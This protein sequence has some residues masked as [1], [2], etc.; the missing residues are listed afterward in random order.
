MDAQ[1]F[2]PF[3]ITII[4]QKTKNKKQNLSLALHADEIGIKVDDTVERGKE[5]GEVDAGIVDGLIEGVAN[6][7]LVVDHGGVEVLNGEGKEMQR[8]CREG[9]ESGGKVELDG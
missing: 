5:V 4:S 2:N 9:W 7:G 1:S 3:L 6:R 8:A